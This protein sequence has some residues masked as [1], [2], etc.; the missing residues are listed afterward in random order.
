MNLLEPL[1]FILLWVS[2]VWEVKDHRSAIAH[3]TVGEICF[4]HVASVAVIHHSV[5]VML[6]EDA[7]LLAVERAVIVHDQLATAWA[8]I[9]VQDFALCCE[10][11][12]LWMGICL[13]R[14]LL[15]GPALLTY[16]LR[17]EKMMYGYE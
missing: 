2:Q 11:Y 10:N 4:G 5:T 12:Y 14:L 8:G 6:I 13:V 17:R 16:D 1:D 9:E 7:A 3:P 15:G